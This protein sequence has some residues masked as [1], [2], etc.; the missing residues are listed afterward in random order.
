MHAYH[1]R[2]HVQ[3]FTQHQQSS[4]QKQ[5]HEQQTSAAEELARQHRKP[6]QLDFKNSRLHEQMPVICRPPAVPLEPE[7][8]DPV[9]TAQ[10]TERK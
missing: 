10:E 7:T 5:Q 4:Q 9:T 2:V 1:R 6:M 3:A 8:P